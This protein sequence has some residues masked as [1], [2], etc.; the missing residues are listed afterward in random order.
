MQTPLFDFD[1]DILLV[2]DHP[3]QLREKRATS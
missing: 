3:F 2:E 1:L